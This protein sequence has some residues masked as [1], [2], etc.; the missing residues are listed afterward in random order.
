MCHVY[1]NVIK[2]A[3]QVQNKE[4]VSISCVKLWQGAVNPSNCYF[5]NFIKARLHNGVKK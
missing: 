2:S 4:F 1:F 3:L 5:F